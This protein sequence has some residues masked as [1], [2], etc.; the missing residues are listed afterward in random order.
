MRK[1][2]NKY[3]DLVFGVTRE[4]MSGYLSYLLLKLNSPSC[5]KFLDVYIS[6]VRCLVT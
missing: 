5:F 1:V 6:C 3:T 2:R 4:K